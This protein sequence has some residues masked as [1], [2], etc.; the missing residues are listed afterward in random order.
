MIWPKNLS[1]KVKHNV[2]LA[3]LTS[4]K[5]GGPARYFFAPADV[6]ELSQALSCAQKAR[7]HIFV[8]GSGSNILISDQGVSGLV[9]SLN[10]Q[11][12]KK[13]SHQGSCI[14]AGSG[15]KLSQLVSY[16]ASRALGGAEFLAGIPGSVGGS[17]I[18]NAGAW[19]YSIGSLVE[20]LGVMDY[21]GKI[22]VLSA[23]QLKFGYRQSNLSKYIIIWVKLKL[24]S[25]DKQTVARQ[26]KKYLAIRKTTQNSRLPSAGCIFKNPPEDSAGRLIDQC[27]LKGKVKGQAA[28]CSKHANFILNTKGARFGDVLALMNLMRKKVKVKFKV[29]LEPEIK[30]W[31]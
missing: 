10:R 14:I 7:L 28:V 8:L 3:G 13:I 9:I 31:K 23:K 18:G 15:L 30:I 27:G 11:S 26:I 17:L 12:F 24:F 2:N 19:G 6:L 20:Q 22:R 1:N 4:F 29:N 5:I 25:A 21:C 16:A